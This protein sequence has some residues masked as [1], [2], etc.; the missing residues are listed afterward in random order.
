MTDFK[1]KI[2]KLY[3]LLNETNEKYKVNEKFVKYVFNKITNNYEYIIK[4]TK[5]IL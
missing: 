2:I 3:K 4:C 1:D 5:Y